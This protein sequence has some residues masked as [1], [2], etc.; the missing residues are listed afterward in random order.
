MKNYLLLQS[1]TDFLVLLLCNVRKIIIHSH[2]LNE[3]W[4]ERAWWPISWNFVTST[5]TVESF[6]SIQKSSE[7]S[8]DFTSFCVITLNCI[9]QNLEYLSS[10]EC[11]HKKINAILHHFEHFLEQANRKFCLIIHF[12]LFGHQLLGQI[13]PQNWRKRPSEIK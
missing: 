1:V 7:I 12:N 10:Q 3:H 2:P 11:Y 5:T 9:N 6:S 8:C 4:M 13:S